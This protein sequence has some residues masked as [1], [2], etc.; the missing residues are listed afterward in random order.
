MSGSLLLGRDTNNRLVAVGLHARG[1]ISSYDFKDYDG[2][3]SFSW[4][5]PVDEAFIAEQEALERQR[6]IRSAAKGTL[7]AN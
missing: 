4:A 2:K 6:E 3:K 7:Q 5:V 1:G